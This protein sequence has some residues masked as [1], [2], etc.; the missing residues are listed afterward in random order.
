MKI[1]IIA[2]GLISIA[3]GCAPMKRE[4][5][6]GPQKINPSQ[7][8]DYYFTIISEDEIEQYGFSEGGTALAWR[9]DK[10]GVLKLVYNWTIIDE[11]T[12]QLK[13]KN[14][15]DGPVYGKKIIE[16]Y[17]FISANDRKAINEPKENLRIINLRFRKVSST[18]A[19]TMEGKDFKRE[20]IRL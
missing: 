10:D 3:T 20:K 16:G 6:D 7:F 2:I 15:L 8:V 17:P 9:G 4:S 19:I 12:L 11:Q 5:S 13:I 1:T 18:H 14:G